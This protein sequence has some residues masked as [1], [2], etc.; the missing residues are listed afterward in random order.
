[1][2]RTIAPILHFHEDYP[3]DML[4]KPAGRM[5]AIAAKGGGR[6]LAARLMYPGIAT[7]I[8]RHC[9]IA[10]AFPWAS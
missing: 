7:F 8:S 4:I 1:M 10:R 6:A 5:K 3:L 2:A 9:H